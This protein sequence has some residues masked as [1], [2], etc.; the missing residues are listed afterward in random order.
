M[1]QCDVKAPI[2]LHVMADPQPNSDV[3]VINLRACP[4][5]EVPYAR[6]MLRRP[7]VLYRLVRDYLVIKGLS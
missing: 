5:P 4:P 2:A 7:T 1:I 3:R 6:E